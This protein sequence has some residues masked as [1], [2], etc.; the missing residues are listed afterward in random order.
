MHWIV[1]FLAPVLRGSVR[2]TGLFILL[3]SIFTKDK[4]AGGAAIAGLIWL[5]VAGVF[6]L[7]GYLRWKATEIASD[8]QTHRHKDWPPESENLRNAVLKGRKHQCR[9][10]LDWPL[11][12]LWFGRC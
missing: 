10:R 12:W 4:D 5:V 6:V 11:A 3:G 9:R 1:L 7:F 2:F 8:E